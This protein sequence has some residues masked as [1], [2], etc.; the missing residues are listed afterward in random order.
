MIENEDLTIY[1]GSSEPI[2]EP[3]HSPDELKKLDDLGMIGKRTLESKGFYVRIASPAQAGPRRERGNVVV[4]VVEDDKDTA[5]VIQKVLETA[6]YRTRHARTRAEIVA[7]ISALPAPD[8]VIL[9]VTL[10]DVDGF[11]VLNRMRQHHRFRP[12]PVLMFTG[13]CQRRD[14]TK[15]L[16]LGADGYLTKPAAPSALL[17]AVNSIVGS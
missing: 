4:L 7:G 15:G 13:H 1:F 11:D 9:D 8:L 14:V 12:I 2:A 16:A 6:G 10:P 5:T 3:S 17:D